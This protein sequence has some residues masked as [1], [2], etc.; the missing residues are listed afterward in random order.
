LPSL[1]HKPCLA[2]EVP[3]TILIPSS[4]LDP[5]ADQF[6]IVQHG[7][8]TGPDVAKAIAKRRY[9]DLEFQADAP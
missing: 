6:Y 5:V 8:V 2:D 7:A 4:R 3:L 9:D 1:A